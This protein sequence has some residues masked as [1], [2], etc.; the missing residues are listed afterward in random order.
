MQMRMAGVYVCRRLA[1]LTKF[2]NVV[3]TKVNLPFLVDQ[4]IAPGKP[5]PGPSDSAEKLRGLGRDTIVAL[6]QQYGKEHEAVQHI[7]KF[8]SAL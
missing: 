8:V 2:R 7:Y 6:A 5:L 4:A 3:L 1:P